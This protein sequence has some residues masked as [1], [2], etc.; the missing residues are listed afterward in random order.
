MVNNWYE[1]ELPETSWLVDGLIPSDGTC[2]FI[3]KPK[4]GKS[5]SARDLAVSVIKGADFIGRKI[6]I[7]EAGRVLYIHLDRKDV[8]A[9]VAQDFKQL[10]VTKSEAKRLVVKIPKDLPAAFPER[11]V[12]LQQEVS[13][14]KPHLVVIDLMM[15]FVVMQNA[16][17]YLAVVEGINKLL[18]ALAAIKFSGA[19]VVTQ[20]SRKA[21]NPN[22]SFDNGLGSTAQRGSLATNVMFERHREQGIYTVESEQTIRDENYG[23]IDKSIIERDDTGKMFLATLYSD[24]KTEERTEAYQTTIR[25]LTDF[26]HQNP[27]CT[28]SDITSY[29]CMSSR[30]VGKLLNRADKDGLI[31]VKGKGVKGDPLRDDLRWRGASEALPAS[32]VSKEIQ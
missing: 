23:E 29:L 2:G 3:G 28:Q 24:Y 17:D 14:L 16:N 1:W 18:D 15:Y 4:S 6:Q 12:W 13:E 22:D 21:D 11:L 30:D 8:P 25:K 19:L 26:V 20:H 7:K 9:R 27:C 32:V 31:I 10:G 5:S